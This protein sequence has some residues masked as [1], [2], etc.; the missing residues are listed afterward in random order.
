MAGYFPS[1]ILHKKQ[2]SGA[3]IEDL[4]GQSSPVT[5]VIWFMPGGGGG[6]FHVAALALFVSIY[7]YLF[8]TFASPQKKYQLKGQKTHGWFQQ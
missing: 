2:E 1:L 8:S 3:R 6:G 7:I 4:G 5:R